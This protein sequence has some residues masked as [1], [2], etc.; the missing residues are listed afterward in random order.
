MENLF[1]DLMPEPQV[2]YGSDNKFADLIPQ[3]RNIFSDLMPKFSAGFLGLPSMPEKAP[4]IVPKPLEQVKVYGMLDSMPTPMSEEVKKKAIE[5][6]RVKEY[7]GIKGTP[8]FS[9]GEM[10]SNIPKNFEDIVVGTGSLLMN[11]GRFAKNVAY[12]MGGIDHEGLN[13]QLQPAVNM[14]D[15]IKKDWQSM[16]RGETPKAIS[17]LPI[18]AELDK[19]F[20]KIERQ[21]L[22]RTTLKFIEERPVD[23][24]LIGQAVKSA[25]GQGIRVT[26]T[27]A[28]KVIPKGT[29]IGDALDSFVSTERTPVV[30]ELPSE[31][32]ITPS[33]EIP[34]AIA[35]TQ[36]E[37][38]IDKSISFPRE[39]SKDPLTKYIFQK[40]FDKALDI[41]PK[42]KEA[43]ASHKAEGL[44]NKLRNTYEK[45]NFQ[46]RV[47][48]NAD[49][50]KQI[51]TLSKEEQ[52]I[53]VPYLEGRASLIGEPSEAFNNFE[54]W[55]RDLSGKIQTDLSQM[56]KLDSETVKG[57]LY[58]PL[59]K[60]TGLTADQ[61]IEE[62]GDFTPAYVHHAFPQRFRQAMG[63]FFAETTGKRF[64]PG[65]LKRSEGVSGYS[66]NLKEILPKFTAEYVKL[67]NTEAFLNDF[68]AKFGIPVNI[69]D[70]KSID[71]GVSVGNKTYK[72]YKIVAPDGYLS[73][74]K[75]K[76]DF[77][78]E[79][80]KRLENMDLDEAMGDALSQSLVGASKE[81]VGVS[82]N[83]VVYLVPE[84]ITK[85]LESYA[86]PL[87]GSQKAHN[88]IK[89]LYDKPVQFWKDS[90]LAVSPRW[91]KNNFIGDIIFNT[92]EGVGPLS[93]GRAFSAKYHD[94]I[95]DNLL[96]ASFANVMKYNPQ[97]GMAAQSTVGQLAKAIGETKVV[98]AVSKAKDM[99]YALNTMFE[100]PFVRSLYVKLARERAVT[101]LKAE[102]AAITEDSILSK[103]AEMKTNPALSDPIISKVEKTLPVFDMTGNVERKYLKRIMPFYNWYKFMAKYTASL[104]INHPFKT[105]GARGLGALSEGQRE[106]AFKEMFPYMKREIEEGGIPDRFDNL[107]PVSEPDKDGKATF[108]NSRGL[109]VF[110]TVEDM[111]KGNVANMM[112]PMVKV[113]VIERPLGRESFTGREYKTGEGGEDFTGK[114]K[115]VPPLGE[116]LLK[117]FPQHELL[118]QFL[119]PAQQYD[120]GTI[121]NPEPILDKITGE[122]KY[123]IDNVEKM[124]N[125]M[126][127]DRK[128]LDIRKVWDSYR[129][130]K[131]T[132]IGETFTKL[133]SKADTALSFQ[134]IKEVFNSIKSDR[135]KWNEILEEIKDRALQLGKEKRELSGKIRQ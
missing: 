17:Q 30:F 43:L 5:E 124:L 85:Q 129:K 102:R 131:T 80:S 105:V 99:G 42:A 12:S 25:V 100:Q 71:G 91:V 110:T 68:T 37:T 23:A 1:S 79:V 62:M 64:T 45:A 113:F 55:Y 75:G 135:K 21:G 49:V 8:D 101:L 116:H 81:Y 84:N 3:E 132:A 125:Y 72:G 93:Y 14:V 32:K 133:Q 83:K 82:K 7:G 35:P 111:V 74:Y 127:I 98:G 58:Q 96:K 4:T 24:L 67:K 130:Q 6:Q 44:I 46:E 117:Q 20:E 40:S 73:F 59:E 109:N 114:E 22:A 16:F 41:F 78:K 51:N 76:V 118:K 48:I 77:F 28:Q 86:T 29:K 121:M 10:V 27:T 53:V 92:T 60:A 134:E 128:T 31:K 33:G 66:E 104:P 108:F 120:T 115:Q 122:Y 34:L 39:Y 56:G 61:I 54:T 2:G 38:V 106:D 19:T 69:K 65:F 119:V 126:G 95:P 123:P 47:A 97:L 88:V 112:S 90:V 52:A 9:F 18:G 36:T 63:A 50:L 107:W 15:A 26:A 103:M 13:K 94:V 87:F 57:R 70:V 89:L 11:I